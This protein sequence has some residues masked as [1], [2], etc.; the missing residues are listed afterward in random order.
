MYWSW[1]IK[2]IRPIHQRYYFEFTAYNGYIDIYNFAEILKEN[3]HNDFIKNLCE[4]VMIR[5]NDTI[6]AIKKSDADLSHG[7]SLYFPDS[8]FHYNWYPGYDRLRSPYENLEFSKNTLWE[9]FV[10]TYLKILWRISIE[11]IEIIN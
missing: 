5:L 11:S 8:R 2:I 1:E 6:C 7:I 3:I 9:E 4:Q 10:K